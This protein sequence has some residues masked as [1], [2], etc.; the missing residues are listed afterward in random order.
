MNTILA[1]IERAGGP[2]VCRFSEPALDAIE[3]SVGRLRNWA[4]VR[5]VGFSGS[6]FLRLSSE[7]RLIVHLP[8]VGCADPRAETGIISGRLQPGTVVVLE[9]V[10]F[11]EAGR[12]AQ[13]IGS[14]L[15]DESGLSGPIEFHA[16]PD[17][18][19]VGALVFPVVHEPRQSRT[20]QSVLA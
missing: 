1:T 7:G 10:A 4:V 13:L 15:E 19:A 14:W 6:P 11:E 3:G 12:V 9:E 18:F 16:G 2:T 20:P 8:I 17:G 5:E